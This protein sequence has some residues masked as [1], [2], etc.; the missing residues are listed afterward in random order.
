MGYRLFK[1]SYT[2]RKGRKK[3][4]AKW[5]VEFRDHLDTVRR[6][7]AFASKSASEEFGRNVV[8]LAAYHKGSGGQQDPALTRWVEGL[9]RAAREKLVS[10]GLLD[11]ERAAAGKPL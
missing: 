7:P 11:A 1:T 9:P 2:D 4:A 8:K 6:L 5:Y 3:E 10:I